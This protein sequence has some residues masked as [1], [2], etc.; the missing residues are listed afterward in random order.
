MKPLTEVLE[1]VYALP[2]EFEARVSLGQHVSLLALVEATGYLEAKD[3][4][5]EAMLAAGL[6]TR[7]AVVNGWLRYSADKQEAWGWFF[8]VDRRGRYGVGLKSG[9]CE[10][11]RGEIADPC[12]AC[13]SFIKE[14]LD[15]IL[16]PTPQ[17]TR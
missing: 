15:A 4:I 7:P 16:G 17:G 10:R 8:E 14:E 13:A 12:S 1:A 11:T 3:V 5:D 2:R 6:R 9:F